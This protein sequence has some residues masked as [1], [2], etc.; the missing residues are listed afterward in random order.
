MNKK[1]I[2][3]KEKKSRSDSP[4]VYQLK[5]NKVSIDRILHAK[6]LTKQE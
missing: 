5:V 1:K 6:K 3:N 2:E 4:Y